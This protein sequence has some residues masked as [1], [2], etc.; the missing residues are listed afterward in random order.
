MNEALYDKL[1]L[2]IMG[3]I[4][5]GCIEGWRE[6]ETNGAL[7]V[8]KHGAALHLEEAERVLKAIKPEIGKIVHHYNVVLA[9]TV[10][11][12]DTLRSELDEQML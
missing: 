12:L 4:H 11:K 6:R 9:R 3:G 2:Y 5:E 1:L 8:T 7:G 10:L